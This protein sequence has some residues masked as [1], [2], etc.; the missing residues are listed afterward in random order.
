MVEP[1]AIWSTRLIVFDK[2]VSLTQN[3]ILSHARFALHAMIERIDAL[4]EM[5]KAMPNL[6][7]MAPHPGIPAIL[8]DLCNQQGIASTILF[9]DRPKTRQESD[10]AFALRKKRVEYVKYWSKQV[11][12][13][14][15]SNR[16]M[17][18]SLTHIDEHLADALAKPKTGWFIDV[19]I[20]K[21]DE[22][23]AQQHGME[24]PREV[25]P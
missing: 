11:P 18:N 9:N 16:K 2:A 6:V 4:H 17:R 8:T 1:S 12:I 5:A 24:I 25:A 14:I 7:N 20:G 3:V 22:F 15:L 10:L 23:T 21:R 13:K 19:A